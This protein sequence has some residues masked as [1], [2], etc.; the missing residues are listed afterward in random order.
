MKNERKLEHIRNIAFCIKS[1]AAGYVT[2]NFCIDDLP[3]PQTSGTPSQQDA[4][5]RGK[6]KIIFDAFIEQNPN[7]NE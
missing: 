6:A 4:Y 5:A 7:I 2:D 1:G 3:A